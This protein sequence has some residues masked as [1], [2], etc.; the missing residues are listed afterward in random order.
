MNKL[1]LVKT[2]CDNKNIWYTNKG[3]REKTTA[4]YI[5]TNLTCL[6]VQRVYSLRKLKTIR[7]P[8]IPDL[9]SYIL[10]IQFSAQRKK[11]W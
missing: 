2:S 10:Y 3:K 9:H 6:Y 11:T 7:I 4:K 1:Q 5:K 8:N